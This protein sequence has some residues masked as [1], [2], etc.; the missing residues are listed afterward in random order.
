MEIR[1]LGK[2]EGDITSQIRQMIADLNLSI[3]AR[4]SNAENTLQTRPM[5]SFPRLPFQ[6]ERPLTFGVER[7]LIGSCLAIT[8]AGLFPAASVAKGLR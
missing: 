5:A 2:Q 4:G 7:L 6:L 3:G 8:L 1:L